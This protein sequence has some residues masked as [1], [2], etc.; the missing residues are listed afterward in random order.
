MSGMK[1]EKKKTPKKST[2]CR[3]YHSLCAFSCK[4]CVFFSC[5][6]ATAL[7]Y[8]ESAY[9]QCVRYIACDRIAQHYQNGLHPKRFIYPTI[10]HS[11]RYNDSLVMCVFLHYLLTAFYSPAIHFSLLQETTNK[12]VVLLE[13]RYAKINHR[14]RVGE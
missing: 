13:R 7:S 9:K 5:I 12:N 6:D 14:K 11:M 3:L 4:R 8:C 10:Q 1:K 2:Q